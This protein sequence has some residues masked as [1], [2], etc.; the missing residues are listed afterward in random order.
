MKNE[1]VRAEEGGTGSVP[2]HSSAFP[3]FQAAAMAVVSEASS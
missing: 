1:E 3:P 2:G